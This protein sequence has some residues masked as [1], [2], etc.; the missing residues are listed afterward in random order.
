MRIFH[1]VGAL[2]WLIL[3][4]ALVNGMVQASSDAL[5][6]ALALAVVVGVRLWYLSEA[7]WW[8]AMRRQWRAGVTH[9]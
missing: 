4:G 7:R 9:E 1:L 8:R 3:L 2:G 5:R 6:L